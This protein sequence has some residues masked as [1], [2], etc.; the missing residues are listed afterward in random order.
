MVVCGSSIQELWGPR[1]LSPPGSSTPAWL[2]AACKLV[3]SRQHSWG[4]CR[5]SFGHCFAM[6]ASSGGDEGLAPRPRDGLAGF[7]G[8]Q[9]LVTGLAWQSA[10][11]ADGPCPAAR[12]HAASSQIPGMRCSSSAIQ[13]HGVDEPEAL[14]EA[15]R[16]SRGLPPSPPVIAPPDAPVDPADDSVAAPQASSSSLGG[17]TG[18]L[19]GLDGDVPVSISLAQRASTSRQTAAMEGSSATGRTRSTADSP[20]ASV[21]VHMAWGWPST[22]FSVV[23]L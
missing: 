16:R 4:E 6:A 1:G 19:R 23:C 2:T 8:G 13:G 22:W 18:V 14:A 10:V 3:C 15:L 5:Q 9:R 7:V 21:G 17:G 20:M 12:R 11:A